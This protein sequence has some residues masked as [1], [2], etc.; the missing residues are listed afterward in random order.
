MATGWRQNERSAPQE[1]RLRLVT[2]D[3]DIA[4]LRRSKEDLKVRIS[5]VEERLARLEAQRELREA[6]YR[7]DA[8]RRGQDAPHGQ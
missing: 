8:Y 1:A 6:A 3:E 7:S 2:Y 5:D 4:E